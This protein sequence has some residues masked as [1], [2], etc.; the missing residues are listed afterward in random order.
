MSKIKLHYNKIDNGRS[1][2]CLSVCLCR[3]SRPNGP[4]DRAETW[5]G[6][7]G[8]LDTVPRLYIF[9][10]FRRRKIFYSIRVPFSRLFKAKLALGGGPR[11]MLADVDETWWEWSG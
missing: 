2:V 6:I 9:P 1:V 4:G 3:A 5:Q 11:P 10:G 7:S 8:Y